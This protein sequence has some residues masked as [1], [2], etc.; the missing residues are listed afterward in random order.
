MFNIIF[1]SGFRLNLGISCGVCRSGKFAQDFPAAAM[2]EIDPKGLNLLI[3]SIFTKSTKIKPP[4][5]FFDPL[6]PPPRKHFQHP[7]SSPTNAGTS[8]KVQL[9]R[10]NVNKVETKFE[11]TYDSSDIIPCKATLRSNLKCW[12]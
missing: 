11:F 8:C 7:S 1:F 3:L 6:F 2:H 5:K 10:K 12:T 9:K 4:L